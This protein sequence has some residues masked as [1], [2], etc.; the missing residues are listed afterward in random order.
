MA[1]VPDDASVP[2]VTAI[3]GGWALRQVAEPPG[4]PHS[5]A[6]TYAAAL[7]GGPEEIL[8]RIQRVLHHPL[9]ACYP[10]GG[11][12][13][14]V[15]L[16]LPEPPPQGQ[17]AAASGLLHELVPALFAAAPNCHRVIAAPDEHD[18]RAQ[19][20]L[21]AGGLRRITEADLPDGSVVLFAVEPPDIAGLSTALDDM[22]H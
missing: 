10:F 3:G 12:D 1:T 7:D 9:R 5:A 6:R 16:V 13:L 19:R 11:H 21:E 17:T 2:P 18:T 4:F 8:V 22:P 15:G 20:V 14:A